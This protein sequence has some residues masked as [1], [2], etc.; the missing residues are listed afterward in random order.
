MKKSLVLLI[1]GFHL[2][3]GQVDSN[4]GKLNNPELSNLNEPI[5]MTIFL[6][7]PDRSKPTLIKSHYKNK[8]TIYELVYDTA[9]KGT[10]KQ[11]SEGLQ[12]GAIT[13]YYVIDTDGKLYERIKIVEIEESFFDEYWMYIAI[14]I[15]IV[16]FAIYKLNIENSRIE[17]KDPTKIGE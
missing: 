2:L 8:D 12:S 1:F 11:L 6:S 15:F 10:A 7:S 4:I 17:I 5:Q 14:F 13:S 3:N 9:Y 16:G